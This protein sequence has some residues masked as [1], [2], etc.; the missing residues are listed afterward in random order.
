[1]NAQQFGGFGLVLLG[2][3]QSV[4]NGVSFDSLEEFTQARIGLP[5]GEMDGFADIVR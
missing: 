5:L 2:L 3:V 4:L 1:M